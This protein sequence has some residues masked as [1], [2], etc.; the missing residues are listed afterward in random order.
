MKVP[1]VPRPGNA[2]RAYARRQRQLDEPNNKGTRHA[3]QT[4]RV[5]E[6]RL[7]RRS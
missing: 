5:L 4:W 1:R 3:Q 2:T 6:E 7:R